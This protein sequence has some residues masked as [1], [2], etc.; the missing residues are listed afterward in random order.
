MLKRLKLTQKNGSVVLSLLLEDSEETRKVWPHSFSVKYTITLQEQKLLM[1]FHVLNKDKEGNAKPFTFTAALHTYFKVADAQRIAIFGL[2]GLTYIDKVA[3]GEKK[4]EKDEAIDFVGETDR[5]Y[6][7]SPNQI[8]VIDGVTHSTTV[9][10]K[11]GFED[12]VIWNPWEV[13]IKE[14]ADMGPDDWKQMCCAESARVGNAVTL[15]HG[16]SWIGTQELSR[17]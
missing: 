14:M 13:K 16:E 11:E 8:Q 10:K 17:L 3:K 1:T 4:V 9:L 6:L 5:V 12:C 2:T 7:Q 15:S